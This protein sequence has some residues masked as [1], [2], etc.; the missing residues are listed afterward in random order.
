MHCRNTLD[1]HHVYRY[2]EV[3]CGYDRVKLQNLYVR[4]CF[5]NPLKPELN[6]SAQR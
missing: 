3:N 4:V 2:C 6:T 1:F 5:L